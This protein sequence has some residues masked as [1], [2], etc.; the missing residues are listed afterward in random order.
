[1]LKTSTLASSFLRS[2]LLKI[3]SISKKIHSLYKVYV[4][5]L[6]LGNEYLL[7]NFYIQTLFSSCIPNPRLLEEELGNEYFTIRF[8]TKY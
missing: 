1:A 4:P 5:K 7:F 3:N 8:L 2:L 6:E